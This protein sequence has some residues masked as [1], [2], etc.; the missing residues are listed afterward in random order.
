MGKPPYEV[1][2]D[3][4]RSHRIWSNKTVAVPSPPEPGEG[5]AQSK[6]API[7]VSPSTLWWRGNSAIA[8]VRLTR[9]VVL[10]WGCLR[11]S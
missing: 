10:R 4:A 9:G 11:K 6:A 8:T 7:N 3:S 1:A 5:D 2:T